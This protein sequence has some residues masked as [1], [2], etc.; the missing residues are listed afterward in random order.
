[1][2]T[3]SPIHERDPEGYGPWMLGVVLLLALLSAAR[4]HAGWHGDFEEWLALVVL[5]GSLL[6]GARV[7]QRI[8]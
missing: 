5:I 4:L 1:M 2:R 3:S 6:A 7:L 8:L